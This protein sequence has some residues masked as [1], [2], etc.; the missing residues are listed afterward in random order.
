[1]A[2]KKVTE[3]EATPKR[4]KRVP[5]GRPRH[6]TA[7]TDQDPNYQYRWIN[8]KQDRIER[9]KAG[10]YEVVTKDHIVGETTLDGGQNPKYGSAVAKQVGGGLWAVL[11]RIPREYYDEDQA[12][13]EAELKKLE[14]QMVRDENKKDER[15]GSFGFK[16]DPRNL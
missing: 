6:V 14:Q 16:A 13:K 2:T 10:G 8:D 9:A 1:M 3:K 7:V 4:V 11:M 15:Y 12:A 5:L